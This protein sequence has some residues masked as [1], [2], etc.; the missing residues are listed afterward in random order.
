MS[1]IGISVK[2]L[3]DKR[4]ITGKGRYTDDIVLPY[5]THVCFVRSQYAHAKINS[6]DISEA[7]EMPGV[8]QIFTGK[9]TDAAGIAGVPCGWQV[10]FINGDIMKEPPHP[11]L[12]SDTVRHAG[13]AVAMVIAETYAEAKD[14]AEAVMVDYEVL[15]AVVSPKA[16][17]QAGAPQVHADAPGNLCF[18]WELGNPKAEVDAAMANAHHVTKLDFIN[19]RV[20]P[21]AIEPRAAIGHYEDHNDKYTLYTSTQNPHLIQKI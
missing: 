11:L 13:D 18:D 7:S 9:D 5:M 17:A 8:V 16:A 15:P 6:I 3:E 1:Y 12:I 2:R 4:F 21:N 10:N 14:A 19:Q 20:I